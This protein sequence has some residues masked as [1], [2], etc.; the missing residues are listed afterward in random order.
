MSESLIGQAANITIIG[1]SVVFVFLVILI[2]MMK[3][4]GIAVIALEKYFPQTV[5]AVQDNTLIAVAIAA[6][7]KFQ[8][9]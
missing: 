7:K 6:A 3:L 2:L 9:K 1:M 4:L 5:P 8:G